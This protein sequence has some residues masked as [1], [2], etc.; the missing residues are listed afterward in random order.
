MLVTNVYLSVL[1]RT[2]FVV[3]G[4]ILKYT[5]AHKNLELYLINELV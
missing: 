4:D 3:P 5:Q 1:Y 2:T